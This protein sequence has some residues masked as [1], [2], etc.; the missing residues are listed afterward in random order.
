VTE[1]GRAWDGYAITGKEGRAGQEGPA[2]MPPI[3]ELKKRGKSSQKKRHLQNGREDMKREEPE[4]DGPRK[5]RERERD[6]RGTKAPEYR[7]D[8]QFPT[9]RSGNTGIG[10]KH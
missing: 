9:A 8:D 5:D 2:N 7:S 6:M 10:H 4:L 3:Y 1:G